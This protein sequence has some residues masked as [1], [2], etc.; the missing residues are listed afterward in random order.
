MQ[1][2]HYFEIAQFVF[3]GLSAILWL[4]SARVRLTP[5]REGL[6]ELDK[7][8]LLAGDLQSASK[9]SGGAAAFMALAVVAQG[10]TLLQTS[11]CV[12]RLF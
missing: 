11:P 1:P 5:V 2:C 12:V 8:H 9:W 3:Y 6:E 10:I 7:V 4:Q